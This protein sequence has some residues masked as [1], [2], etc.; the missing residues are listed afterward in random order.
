[1]LFIFTME[2]YK[3]ARLMMMVGPVML[4]IRLTT[5]KALKF[6]S[7]A[8]FSLFCTPSAPAVKKLRPKFRQNGLNHTAKIQGRDKKLLNLYNS[9]LQLHM[10]VIWCFIN[11]MFKIRQMPVKEHLVHTNN[12]EN[13]FVSMHRCN[14]YSV[15]VCCE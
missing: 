5:S 1:M 13:T 12:F 15:Y 8:T 3:R 14:E 2:D 10:R 6:S 7:S 9:F 11:T 4:V